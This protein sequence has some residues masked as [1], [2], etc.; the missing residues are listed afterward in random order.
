VVRPAG[1]RDLCDSGREREKQ[2]CLRY[3]S[4]ITTIESEQ[5]HYTE[6][7]PR[8]LGRSHRA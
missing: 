1:F 6:S 8:K 2:D 3:M 7:K 4:K 5:L